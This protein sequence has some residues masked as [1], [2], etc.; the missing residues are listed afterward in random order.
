MTDSEQFLHDEI[1]R[2]AYE[3]WEQRGRP[4]GS[5]EQNWLAVE[6]A[7][8][9]HFSLDSDPSTP[10]IVGIKMAKEETI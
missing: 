4:V 8:R 6:K 1:A 9:H 7:V 3:L 5:S 2:S 10:E